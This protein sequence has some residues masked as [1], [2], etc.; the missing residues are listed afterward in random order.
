[1]NCSSLVRASKCSGRGYLCQPQNICLCD[2]GW[3]SLN[4]YSIVEGDNCTI[5]M[6]SIMYLSIVDLIFAASFLFV[7]LRHISVRLRTITCRSMETKSVCTFAF[8]A[9]GVVDFLLAISKLAYGKPEIIG[10]DI[11]HS[12]LQLL[13]TFFCFVSLTLYYR[14]VLKFLR[15]YSRMMSTNDRNNL[16]HRYDVLQKYSWLIVLFSLPVSGAPILAYCYQS[17]I[18]ILTIVGVAGTGLLVFIYGVFL[19]TAVGLLLA[20]LTPYTKSD[21]S[22]FVGDLSVVCMRMRITFYLGGGIIIFGASAMVI[23]GSWDFLRNK[24]S[25]ILIISRIIGMSLFMILT[26]TLSRIASS[27]SKVGIDS[28]HESATSSHMPSQHQPSVAR[29]LQNSLPLSVEDVA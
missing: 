18:V 13:F 3:T 28:R 22:A 19:I 6:S 26:M 25:Y 17:H 10:R 4:D 23:F 21:S 1:M 20:E 29:N 11:G 8:A 5:N 9:I 16:R 7:I 24:V 27:S 14:V 15:G 12:V 2:V